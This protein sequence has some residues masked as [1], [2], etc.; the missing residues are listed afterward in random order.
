MRSNVVPDTCELTVDARTIHAFDNDRM[1]ATIR[2]AVSSEV[3]VLSSRLK[4]VAGS[5]DWTIAKAALE[6]APGSSVT[7][8]PSVSD[9][10]HMA[11]RPAIVFGPGTSEQSH[12]ADESIS[13]AKLAAAPET[14]MRL[15]AAWFRLEG[16]A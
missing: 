11:G 4:P 8:F 6:A 16:A 3:E 5:P 10:A 12:K 7:G 15:I 14:Y 2:S 13:V 1:I 9:L